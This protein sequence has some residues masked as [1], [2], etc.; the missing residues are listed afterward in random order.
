MDGF[1][2]DA[3][4]RR[5]AGASSRRQLMRTFA[6]AVG[7]GLLARGA[8]TAR[9]AGAADACGSADLRECIRHAAEYRAYY[10]KTVCDSFRRT[11]AGRGGH[12]AYAGC[13]IQAA[14][15]ERWLIEHCRKTGGCEQGRSCCG[16]ACIDTGS[17]AANCGACGQACG[18]GQICV[19]GA[20]ECPDGLTLC[21]G[22]CVDTFSD[23]NN[24]RVCGV[25]C[26]ECDTCQHGYCLPQTC[27]G[28]G[29]CCQSACYPPCPGSQY[30]DPAS[31]GCT[32]LNGEEPCGDFCCGVGKS[33]CPD[34]LA[35]KACRDTDPACG[36]CRFSC[37]DLC[38]ELDER[39][40][41]NADYSYQCVG[42]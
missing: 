1:G 31:C 37:G 9:P 10:T 25:V 42:D 18:G 32:C 29:T 7:A 16:G 38:C 15:T 28:D 11:H 33:C 4:T 21:D 8:E 40:R 5:L 36:G 17:D 3:L 41:R 22:A 6:G 27:D 20:C 24:C 12:A 13:V 14:R 34:K 26:G 23:S 35:G 30:R 39:C 19:F 2:F